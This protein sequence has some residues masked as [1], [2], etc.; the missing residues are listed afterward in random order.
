MNFFTSKLANLG[1]RQ[2]DIEKKENRLKL[3]IFKKKIQKPDERITKRMI[4]MQMKS[5]RAIG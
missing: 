3:T 5:T 1:D 2:K 4:D